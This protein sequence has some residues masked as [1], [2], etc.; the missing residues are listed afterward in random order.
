MSWIKYLTV[1]DWLL[2][3]DL[4]LHLL[5]AWH[6]VLTVISPSL[7]CSLATV[8]VLLD[9][10]HEHWVGPSALCF[11]LDELGEVSSR[12]SAIYHFPRRS[13][14]ILPGFNRVF[15]RIQ[16]A[17]VFY[18][19]LE[20]VD[21]GLD[22]VDLL[23]LLRLLDVAEE[24]LVV[25]L[26]LLDLVGGDCPSPCSLLLIVVPSGISWL[27]VLLVVVQLRQSHVHAAVYLPVE[28]RL[29]LLFP[30][31][32]IVQFDLLLLV[33]LSCSA[34]NDIVGVG[35]ALVRIENNILYFACSRSAHL[36]V[37]DSRD[38]SDPKC[39]GADVGSGVVT[40]SHKVVFVF[41][42]GLLRLLCLQ[43]AHVLEA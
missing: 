24:G 15:M 5:T 22:L 26:S 43:K 37:E 2:L 4:C 14:E 10:P 32:H 3:F 12:R 13:A 18:L 36:A 25:A 28:I 17:D 19:R 34:A 16:L 40:G 41:I 7:T 8:I 39:L 31:A 23:L 33:E 20:L 38:R 11:R 42:V 35:V 27:E 29:G 9:H 6:A 21:V 1:F 30:V